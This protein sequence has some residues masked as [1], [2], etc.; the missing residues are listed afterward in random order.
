MYLD[1]IA[2]VGDPAAELVATG[3]PAWVVHSENGG[4]GGLTDPERVT[5]DAAGNVTL[6]TVPGSVFL[7]PD[8]VPDQ[9]ARVIADAVARVA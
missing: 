4:D 9:V 8:E 3:V 2:T 1:H 5:L 6:V 7:L